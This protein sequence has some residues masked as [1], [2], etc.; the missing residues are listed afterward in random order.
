MIVAAF[1]VYRGQLRIAES[2][3]LENGQL[4]DWLEKAKEDHARSIIEMGA[5]HAA[6]LEKL[7]TEQ[8]GLE[9]E[10]I[11]PVNRDRQLYFWAFRVRITHNHPTKT[12]KGVCVFLEDIQYEKPQTTTRPE[13]LDKIAWPWPL[14]EMRSVDSSQK[15]DIASRPN[16]KEFDVLMVKSI[17]GNADICLAPYVMPNAD[18]GFFLSEVPATPHRICKSKGAEFTAVSFD[19]PEAKFMVTIQVTGN[20]AKTV[21]GQAMLSITPS[22]KSCFDPPPP[23]WERI[24]V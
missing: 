9:V 24:A 5:E 13:E 14:P 10:F 21:R 19:A 12:A 20:G 22:S 8:I 16:S 4:R 15:H 18:A 6:E 2:K 7:K 23:H 1:R 11:N 3:K 17:H